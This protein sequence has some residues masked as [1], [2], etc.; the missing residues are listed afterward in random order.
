M[1]MNRNALFMH[2]KFALLPYIEYKCNS[3]KE[4]IS[5]SYRFMIR[6][7]NMKRVVGT[8]R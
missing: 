6:S 5:N 2:N 3:G 8:T 1:I 7:V 4:E